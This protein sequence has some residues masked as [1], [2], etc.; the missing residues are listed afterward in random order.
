MSDDDR[1]R[2]VAAL[3]RHT[4]AGRLSLDEFSDRV[5]RALAA[6]TRHDLALVTSDLPAEPDPA[7]RSGQL[8]VAFGLAMATLAVLGLV[9]TLAR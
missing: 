1:M 4:A 3:E 7:A 5:A 6:A 9:I 2:V 8:L